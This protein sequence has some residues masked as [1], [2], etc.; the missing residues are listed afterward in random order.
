MQD[1][2]NGYGGIFFDPHGNHPGSPYAECIARLHE[3]GFFDGGKIHLIDPN[4][5]LVIPI[6]PLAR[7][8]GMDRMR[9][10]RRPA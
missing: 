4:T 3:A 7:V 1:I 8:H 10:C 5:R 9:H 6:N 2:R